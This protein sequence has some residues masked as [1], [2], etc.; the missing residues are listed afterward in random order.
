MFVLIL[1][2]VLI[3]FI[4]SHLNLEERTNCCGLSSSPN[5]AAL[6]RNL[7]IFL[8]FTKMAW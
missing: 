7:L 6:F 2:F 5:S 8:Y 4:V 1:D 3:L